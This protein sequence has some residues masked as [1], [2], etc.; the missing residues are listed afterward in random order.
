MSKE[1]GCNA[2]RLSVE[3]SIIEPREGEFNQAA[4]DHYRD[5]CDELIKNGITPMI[6][7]HHFTHPQWFEEK[8]HLKK[9]QT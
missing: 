6:T 5:L 9:K 2:F 1:L 7:L 4:I 3:W 8:A